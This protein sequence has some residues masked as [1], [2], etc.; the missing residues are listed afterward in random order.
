M[1]FAY[2]LVVAGSLR[3]H[4]LTSVKNQ[5]DPF[6]VNQ[7]LLR[8]QDA[9]RNTKCITPVLANVSWRVHQLLARVPLHVEG[10][11]LQ[12]EVTRADALW[13]VAKVADLI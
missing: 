13:V 6:K 2:L 10:S 8:P 3:T 7:L 4:F 5:K 1:W 12:A 11:W 9:G